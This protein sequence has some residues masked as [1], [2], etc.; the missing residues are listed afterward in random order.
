MCV[1]VAAHGDPLLIAA[2]DG[3]EDAVLGVK[4]D[5]KS[6]RRCEMVNRRVSRAPFAATEDAASI[7]DPPEIP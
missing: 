2:T 3:G 7:F 1:T 5:R 4:D 6:A